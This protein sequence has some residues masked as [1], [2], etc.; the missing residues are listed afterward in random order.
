MARFPKDEAARQ[1]AMIKDGVLRRVVESSLL[2]GASMNLMVKAFHKLYGMP[3]VDP[4]N[5]KMNFGHISKD[6]LGMRFG[7]IVE[8][9]ME[10]CE[11]MDIRADIRFLVEDEEGDFKYVG[12]DITE[13][14]HNN[15]SDKELHDIVR[16]RCREAINET[17]ERSL[18]DIADATFDLKYVIIG[19]EYE[20][21]IDPQFAAEEGHASNMTKLGEDGQVIRRD[22]GKVMKGPNF[23][24]PDMVRALK[25][26][27]MRDL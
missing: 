16:V 2:G 14:E 24:R 1:A 3:I 19:F 12:K 7:L 13:E 6:R 22:D 27:G 17:D 4:S 8:E 25:A 9:F 11:A 20:V 21:G 5:A 18:P 10:L 26:W 23:V 15:L